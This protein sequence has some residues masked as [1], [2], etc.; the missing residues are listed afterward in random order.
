MKIGVLA[1]QGAFAEHISVLNRLGTGAV[2]VRLSPELDGL[3]GLIIPG[4]ESTSIS[5]LLQDFNLTQKIKDLARNGLPIF[6]TCAGMILLSANSAGSF[7]E[8]LD[9]M[10]ITAK[11]NA[12][13]RQVDS[14]E[15]DLSIPVLGEKPFPSIF[16]RAPLLEGT[17]G[18]V[19][20]LAKLDDGTIVAARQDKLL[21]TSFH[22]EL[23]DDHRFHQYFVNIIAG[24]Q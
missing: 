1:A 19:E 4:G 24:N 23:T 7:P 12:F 17:N 2:P 11:R 3:D 18:K 22:P 6:G 8:T 5:K 14:F 10:E 21:V 20:I 16:I 15:V 13:G 9:L